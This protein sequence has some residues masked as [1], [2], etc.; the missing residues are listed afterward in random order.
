[1]LRNP[2]STSNT[3]NSSTSSPSSSTIKNDSSVG[4]NELENFSENSFTFN[5]IRCIILILV[6]VFIFLLW[7]SVR[8]SFNRNERID[9]SRITAKFCPPGTQDC[10]YDLIENW[11]KIISGKK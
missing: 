1:M 2:K 6:F 7:N 11:R 4:K 5:L 10:T 9:V 8:D 3:N